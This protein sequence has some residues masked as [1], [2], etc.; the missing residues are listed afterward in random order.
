[1]NAFDPTKRAL[2]YDELNDKIF[3]WNPRDWAGAYNQYAK[4]HDKKRGVIEW[5]GLLLAGWKPLPD[6]PDESQM[7]EMQRPMGTVPKPK[8]KPQAT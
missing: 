7:Q 2:V 1:M 3:E 4:T 5:D 6:D 8:R